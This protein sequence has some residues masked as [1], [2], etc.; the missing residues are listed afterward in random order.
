MKKLLSLGAKVLDSKVFKIADK[1]LLGGVVTNV[2][3]DSESHPRGKVN[4]IYLIKTIGTITL[5]VL[6]ALGFIF[7]KLTM[8]DVEKLFKLLK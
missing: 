8:E 7:G 3:E 1:A 2:R 5:P 4:I 6:L